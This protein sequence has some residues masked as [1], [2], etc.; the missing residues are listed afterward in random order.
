MPPTWQDRAD[1]TSR[2]ESVSKAQTVNKSPN[3]SKDATMK[4]P[5]QASISV[6][7]KSKP[8]TSSTSSPVFHQEERLRTPDIAVTAME[9][10]SVVPEDGEASTEAEKN[11]GQVWKCI[12][13]ES[14]KLSQLK[15]QLK[16]AK[17]TLDRSK[18]D[19]E[20]TKPHHESYPDFKKEF[21]RNKEEA[22]TAFNSCKARV[23]KQEASVKALSLK[24]ARQLLPAII[25][26]A[27][28]VGSVD[29]EKVDQITK[30][31]EDF[32]KLLESQQDLIEELQRD[33]E[34]RKKQLDAVEQR[35]KDSAELLE[36]E[37]AA[38]RTEVFTRISQ[39]QQKTETSIDTLSNECTEAKKSADGLATQFSLISTR[40]D[41]QE[42]TI[43]IINNRTSNIG[44]LYT[45]FQKYE[46]E[47]PEV[48]RQVTDLTKKNDILSQNIKDLEP[49]KSLP[50]TLDSER[51][52]SDRARR[53][54]ES[55]IHVVELRPDSYS[56][57]HGRLQ[58]LER[59]TPQTTPDV[60]SKK[61][62]DALLDRVKA[63]EQP[64][65]PKPTPALSNAELINL[66]SLASRLAKLENQVQSLSQNVSILEEIGILELNKT[67]V[68]GISVVQD[69][70]AK[71]KDI[72]ARIG[73]SDSATNNQ[74]LEER[75]YSLSEDF[76][77]CPTKD[78][79]ESL[80]G[81]LRAVEEGSTALSTELVGTRLTAL[82]A[83]RPSTAALLKPVDLPPI[84][85]RLSA[86]ERADPARAAALLSET[87]NN[88]HKTS[89]DRLTAI[90]NKIESLEESQGTL[91]DSIGILIE[92]GIAQASADIDKKF[93]IM[94]T[95]LETTDRKLG[96]VSSTVERAETAR[97]GLCTDLENT[98]VNLTSM[99]KARSDEL[100]GKVSGSLNHIKSTFNNESNRMNN[101]IMGLGH[102]LAGLT[103]RMDTINTRDLAQNMLG[104]LSEVYP[105]MQN[106][107]N[108][109]QSF[110][111]SLS[112]L[113]DRINNLQHQPGSNVDVQALHDLRT[114]V[115][116]LTRKLNEVESAAKQAEQVANSANEGLSELSAD[117]HKDRLSLIDSIAEVHSHIENVKASISAHDNQ[118]QAIQRAP[119]RTPVPTLASEMPRTSVGP[120]INTRPRDGQRAAND[121][122]P[123]AQVQQQPLS[124]SATPA[125]ARGVSNV[126]PSNG[127]SNGGARQG[128]ASSRHSRQGSSASET[129]PAS[130]AQNT[131]QIGRQISKSRENI[132]PPSNRQTSEASNS[133]TASNNLKRKHAAQSAKG[134]ATLKSSTNGFR[135]RDSSPAGSPVHKK[136]RGRKA[137]RDSDDDEDYDPEDE[138]P[139][140]KAMVGSD[141]D[142]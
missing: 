90:E 60:V 115:D 28:G 107:Q 68:G 127:L 53:N 116:T 81:R 85:N 50:S 140:P 43:T 122:T 92:E 139:Q 66:P 20:R 47:V 93:Q 52:A 67:D 89:Q 131:Q 44:S 102:T 88:V 133:S 142:E 17:K 41:S 97:G 63:V 103:S 120:G 40:V 2:R 3:V 6:S 69:N 84:Q 26:D 22:E 114:E 80:E 76:K 59:V 118:L 38:L 58:K 128:S 10:T 33:K 64:P 111:K 125:S 54:L 56:L 36:K 48:S 101:D 75:L 8:Q 24:S 135:E 96:T 12:A 98:K 70:Q 137:I 21:T 19:F 79:I 16:S 99:I 30:T 34:E 86:L 138:I 136:V 65:S 129:G 62:L 77:N 42:R 15:F 7:A 14:A 104:Q 29:K 5:R 124:K 112:T 87:A 9:T 109:L 132:R 23:E 35:H 108:T 27:R 18:Q 105:D 110:R 74:T 72:I 83:A 1:R 37:L 45:A 123:E 100:E 49:L 46:Q 121:G 32:K 39:A 51:E 113:D 73:T 61:E 82:E 57:L 130:R 106:T 71:I 119:S 11:L 94:A 134:N 25:T 78:T 95:N 91:Q 117:Y 13:E 31:C 141:D 55:R 4:P 126:Q